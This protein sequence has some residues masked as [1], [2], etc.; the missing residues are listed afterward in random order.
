VYS[1]GLRYLV[2]PEY[3]DG[4][5]VLIYNHPAFNLPDPLRQPDPLK[6]EKYFGAGLRYY[7]AGQY[8][9][10]EREFLEAYRNQGQD[11]RI[12]Y[13]LGLSR[14]PQQGKRSAALEVFRM[15]SVLEQQNKP[16]PAAVNA[17][18][19]RIQGTLRQTLNAYRP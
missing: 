13:Y 9:A 8:A 15:A 12:L 3:A 16:S 6:A 14:L 18:L 17:S 10:A 11:A 1:E 7:F 4:L 2:R 19:E 5:A